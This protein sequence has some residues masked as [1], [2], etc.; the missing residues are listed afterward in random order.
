[1]LTK[2]TQPSKDQ[3]DQ[4]RNQTVQRKGYKSS[5]YKSR[6]LSHGFPQ[7]FLSKLVYSTYINIDVSVGSMST[8]KFAANG[9]YD[10]D[11]SSTGH[12]PNPFDQLMSFY[13]KATVIGSMIRVH[14]MRVQG[15]TGATPLQFGVLVSDDG[16]AN[17]TLPTPEDFNESPLS[18]GARLKIANSSGLTSGQNAYRDSQFAYYSMKKQYPGMAVSDATMYNLITNNPTDVTYY[19]CLFYNILNNDPIACCF[20]VIITYTAL[21]Y[22]PKATTPS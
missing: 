9:L 16:S 10:P 17:I 11:L 7:K 13:K 15:D 4:A 6:P 20:Q 3:I 8:Y 5:P 2:R 21:F 19:E 1:M 12:Q 22:E 14:P 18:K